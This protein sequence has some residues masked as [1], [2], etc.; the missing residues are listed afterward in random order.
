MTLREKRPDV[1]AAGL[2]QW[3]AV[4]FIRAARRV[5]PDGFT[6]EDLDTAEATART[7]WPYYGGPEPDAGTRERGSVV[8]HDIPLGPNT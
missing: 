5:T 8:T 1:V 3:L 6:D 4:I 2:R 7:M